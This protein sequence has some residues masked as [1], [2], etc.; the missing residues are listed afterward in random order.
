MTSSNERRLAAYVAEQLDAF[1]ITHLFMVPAVLR[2][3][4]AEIERTTSITAVHTHGEKSAAYM[5]DGFARVSG[6][7]AVCMAQQVGALNLAAGLRDAALASSPVVAFTGGTPPLGDREG[8][9]Q[10]V[11]DLPAFTNYT[12]FNRAAVDPAAV[13]ELLHGAFRIAASGN[14]GPVHLQF[15]GQE[16]ELDRLVAALPPVAPLSIDAPPEPEPEVLGAILDRLR[17]AE[18]PLILAGGG[19]IKAGAA[20]GLRRLSTEAGIPVATSLSG[21]G[22]IAETDPLSVGV[23]GTYSRPSANQIAHEADVVLV[24]GSSLGSMVTN[25][26][27]MPT[28]TTEVLRLDIDPAALDRNAVPSLSTAGD[29]RVALATMVGGAR[30][31]YRERPT[32]IGR[33]A[34]AASDWASERS[35]STGSTEIPI[36]PARLCAEL[37]EALPDNGVIAVDTGHAGMWMASMF[38]ISSPG[39]TFIRS[40]GHLGWAFSAALGA[41]CALPDRPVIAFTGDLGFWYH[42]AEIETAV[43]HGINTVTVVNNNH[44]GNQSRRGFMLAY[45]GEET[46]ASRRLWVHREVD[47]AAIATGIGA[48]GMRVEDP[49]ELAAALRDAVA[50]DAPVVVDVVTDI[51]AAAPTAWDPT[52]W[53]QSY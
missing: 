31:A 28:P 47:F 18:R 51:D 37:T 35:S 6:T 42:I 3:T 32:W 22:A 30:S 11:D 48:V 9:Y 40:S 1:G 19:V 16:G 5:A 45:D 23:I 53:V 33:I 27:R 25:F 43:R 34:T 36:H 14:P 21:R 4:L 39:Q 2:R 12:K 8:L 13:P 20:A 15:E 17:D 24:I 10:A 49:A 46:E 41:K 7:P 26:W 29:L 50:A 38:E 52:G 44:S